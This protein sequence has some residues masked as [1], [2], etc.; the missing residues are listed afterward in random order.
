MKKY[1]VIFVLFLFCSGIAFSQPFEFSPGIFTKPGGCNTYLV[2]TNAGYV[3]IDPGSEGN[4][5]ADWLKSKKDS[6]KAVILTHG[7][8]DH[9]QFIK[10][11]HE[12]KVP[13]YVNDEFIEFQHYMVRLSGFYAERNLIQGVPA[14]D[15]SKNPGNFEATIFPDHFFHN[16]DTLIVGSTHFIMLHVGG[17]TPDQSLIWIPEKKAVFIGD[18]Y[19][20]SFPA[21][22]TLRGTKPRWALDYIKALDMALKI[23]PEVLYSGHDQP[24]LGAESIKKMVSKYRNAIQ[25]VHDETVKGM[26]DGKDVFTLMQ[27]I[28]LPDSL[29]IPEFFGRVSWS[30]RGIYEGYVGWFNGNIDNMYALPVQSIYPDLITLAGGPDSLVKLAE[31]YKNQ[32]EYVKALHVSSMILSAEKNNRGALIVRLA[33][34]KELR[35]RSTNNVENSW[36]NYEIARITSLVNLQ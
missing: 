4:P 8:A 18:N 6:V 34:L 25:Y 15:A 11:W 1:V 22:Y 17:E 33:V 27:E 35:S 9:T 3:L 21:L 16:S 24:I 29:K 7:H 36:L 32:G 28:S 26:N 12:K 20:T 2:K 30:V 14:T 23:N 13:I 19:F 31:N 5:E 10:E